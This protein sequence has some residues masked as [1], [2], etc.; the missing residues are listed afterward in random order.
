MLRFAPV[1]TIFLFIAPVGAGFAGAI[2]PAFGFFPALGGDTV[3]LDPWRDLASYPGVWEATFRSLST[4]LIA[5]L[6]SL[7]VTIVFTAAWR[8]TDWFTGFQRLLAP[9][10][11]IP[12]AAVALG[13]VFLLAPSGWLMRFASPWATGFERPPDLAMAPDPYGI[14]F[15]LCLVVKEV[16]FLF[17]MMLS[18][19]NQTPDN[20]LSTTAT[21]YG[22]K[23]AVGWLKSAAPQVL[24]Q[25]RLPILAVLAYSV[26]VVDI[27][28]ILTP[29]TKP[30]MS[31]LVLR[32][33]SDPDLGFQFVAAAGACLQTLIVIL[34]G[35]LWIL[36][37]KAVSFF[38]RIWISSGNRSTGEWT[39][40][41]LSLI[42]ISLVALMGIGTIVITFLWSIARRWRFPDFLPERIT[43]TYWSSKLDTLIDPALLTISLATGSAFIA[44][45]LAVLCLE[46]ETSTKKKFEGRAL[47]ILYTPLL[48]PQVAFLF[49]LQVL[50]AAIGADG[51][52]VAL[53]WSHLV[54]VGP[55][56]F[57]ALSGSYRR[58]DDRYRIT[59]TSLGLTPFKRFLSVTVPLLLNPLLIA[60]AVGVAVSVGQYLPTVFAGA[61]R[62]ET[63]TT[64]AINLA[65]GGDRRVVAMLAFGQSIIPLIGFILAAAIPAFVFHGK[66][67]MAAA[68]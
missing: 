62:F 61:G 53:L 13:M 67:E 51:H 29:S 7:F 20:K 41:T 35:L 26:S 40:Q 3:S 1:L 12:H 46:N 21:T 52:W 18:A 43:T 37:E 11:S 56:V 48:A 30:T 24:V 23:Q 22:Y 6:I 2:V 14:V 57:V 63:L 17:L 15:V 33:F 54:F 19:L 60:F 16:P 5:T 44:L 10:L 39:L 38:Y 49:G 9:L 8:R 28:L 55:Y 65:A 31:V 47:W 32:W 66:Q 34:A 45:V 4:G 27:A 64:E 25:M 58:L 50:L 59:A 36:G 42:S 68:R